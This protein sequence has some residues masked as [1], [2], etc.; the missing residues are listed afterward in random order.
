M[1]HNC[2]PHHSEDRVW[3]NQI[4]NEQLPADSRRVYTHTEQ[5]PVPD[6]VKLDMTPEIDRLNSLIQQIGNVPR[7][8][9]TLLND[10]RQMT[11][12]IRILRNEIDELK[13]TVTRQEE[14]IRQLTNLL[15]P[16]QI[17]EE[18]WIIPENWGHPNPRRSNPAN[19]QNPWHSTPSPQASAPSSPDPVLPPSSPDPVL[20]PPD[21]VLPPSSPDPM[22]PPSPPPSQS[23]RL[24]AVLQ[25]MEDVENLKWIVLTHPD[26]E[27][28][29]NN[30]HRVMGN[31]VPSIKRALSSLGLEQITN[32]AI[33]YKLTA[34][35]ALKIK[36]IS[37][38]EARRACHL[39][40]SII[41][42][43][44]A[45]GDNT[46]MK[47]STIL[48]PRWGQDRQIFSDCAKK[49]KI[50][51]EIVSWDCVVMGAQGLIMKTW[52][53]RRKRR[54][55]TLDEAREIIGQQREEEIREE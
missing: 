27:Q 23:Q 12:V 21:P 48:S 22:L 13:E 36:F 52:N 7:H 43:I 44:R 17:R 11:G 35:G 9:D 24:T 41:G 6:F 5:W 46:T 29:L 53:R 50:S 45:R 1:T 49:L 31:F 10:T 3:K 55:F 40:R 18:D 15:P 19:G 30:Q 39:L 28:R 33:G 42:Q 25:K 20:P 47:F 32:N 8:L 51:G 37:S 14:N 26:L 34:S 38:L 16:D 4:Q 2:I 54:F